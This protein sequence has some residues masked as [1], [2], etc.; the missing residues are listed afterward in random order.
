[1]HT[2]EHFIVMNYICFV[3]DMFLF[4]LLNHFLSLENSFTHPHYQSLLTDL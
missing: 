3:A 2:P 1:M 4:L